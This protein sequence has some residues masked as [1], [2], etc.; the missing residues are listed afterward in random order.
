[1]KFNKPYAFKLYQELC[2]VKEI[3]DV[4]LAT[5]DDKQVQANKTILSL[6][7]NFFRNLF[8]SKSHHNLFIY[9]KDIHYKCL[10]LIIEFIYTGQCDIEEQD[11]EQFLL[12]GK[13]LR[14]T[15][16]LKELE[17]D[18]ELG[19]INIQL[20]LGIQLNRSNRFI[21]RILMFETLFPP[22]FFLPINQQN[23]SNGSIWCL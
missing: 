11:I 18:D 1:M 17:N 20:Q 13:N 6:G 4:T 9:L 16:L 2:N 14:V 19:I 7:S 12:A 8:I 21:H 23:T 10:K 22:F 15:G 3:A 5:V